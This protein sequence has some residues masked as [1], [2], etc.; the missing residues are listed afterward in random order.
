MT[1]ALLTVLGCSPII[2]LMLA[3]CGGGGGG[4]GN[5]P[6]PGPGPTIEER[7]VDLENYV[8]S[9][10]NY[11]QSF[12][13]GYFVPTGAD[14]GQFDALVRSLLNQD[15]D[16]VLA[17]V[18]GINFKLVRVF[19]T[20]AGNNELY[21]L[22]ELVLRGQGFYCADFDASNTHHVS[23]PHPLY[24]S[25]TN[26]ESVTVMRGTG[27]RFLSISS[28][29]RCSTAATS[30]CSGTTTACGASG[31]YKVSDLAHNV[32]S[33]FYRFGKV[34]HDNSPSTHTLQLH[35]C[36][37]GSCPSNN[38]NAD[39]VARLSAGTTDN[40][41]ADE[42]VNLLNA[43]LNEEL[44]TLQSGTS[45]S[46][47]EPSADKQLC[48]TTNTLGRYINGQPNPCQNSATVFTGSRWLHIEQ[49]ANL[50]RD[51]GGGDPVTPATLVNAIND[52]FGTP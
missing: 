17:N 15:L 12:S 18:G 28:T 51:D 16:R 26:V 36:G 8:A 42:L 35:G 41:P 39:I 11:V 44:A 43:E 45:V 20:G 38:D 19:D 7:T 25:V 9:S 47:S 21:C 37:S 10:L 50:R 1:H 27:A 22:E 13:E 30:S 46:C 29:H 48:G 52:T 24:D 34:V 32:D 33:F 5:V 3:G 31:A 14:L 2:A 40:L 23:V 4:G 6:P 49:N